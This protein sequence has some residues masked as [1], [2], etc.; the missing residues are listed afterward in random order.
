MCILVQT[1]RR[2]NWILPDLIFGKPFQPFLKKEITNQVGNNVTII[3]ININKKIFLACLNVLGLHGQNCMVNKNCL[4]KAILKIFQSQAF[5][6]LSQLSLS[7]LSLSELLSLLHRWSL[8]YLVL[9][10]L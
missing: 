4:Y 1:A 7:F 3:N 6:L 10:W 5:K 8:K 2:N 9:F